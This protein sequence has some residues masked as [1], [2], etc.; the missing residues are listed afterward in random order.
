MR[1]KE[2]MHMSLAEIKRN[3]IRSMLTI[4]G[5][6]I[7]VCAMIIV[8]SVGDS[9]QDSV[10]SELEKFGINRLFIYPNERLDK[11]I[12]SR[13][14][15]DYLEENI[16]S[17]DQISPQS[18]WAGKVSYSGK[19][20]HVELV[21][22]TPVLKDVENKSLSEGR[23]ISNSDVE[24]ARKVIVL[25]DEVKEALF[26]NRSAVGETVEMAGK[27][28]TVIGV[29]KNTKPL[30]TSIV[31]PKSYMPIT[32]YESL[33]NVSSIA[34]IS[35]TVSNSEDMDSVAKKAVNLLL[36]KHG[37][38]SI[39]TLNLAEEAKNAESILTI[40]KLVIG[41]VAMVSLLV[42]GIGIMNIMLVTVR[43]RT[44]EIG[45]RKALG[46]KNS[47]ILKQF[48]T[49]SILY[50]LI[51]SVIGI[52]FGITLS[53]L[54]ESIIGLDHRISLLSVVVSVVFSGMIGIL[55]GIIP[56]IKAANLDPSESLRH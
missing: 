20:A 6:V 34:E 47:V 2:Y 48:L 30:Y 22:T 7:G 36:E 8:V 54:V 31:A 19:S 52:L 16:Q 38:S 53:M 39:K 32:T 12:L 33:F 50:A 17:I 4:L 40:F 35:I 15:I 51:G 27:K 37:D 1:F 13:S 9:G 11:T 56:A 18:F 42:G 29:E 25:S 46:A 3:F 10:Y 24:Y 21:A 55:F 26:K 49:E 28:F 45:I 44:K 23:F 43:E 41:A 14:D 5:I